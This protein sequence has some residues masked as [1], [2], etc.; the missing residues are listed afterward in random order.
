MIGGFLGCHLQINNCFGYWV[1]GNHGNQNGKSGGKRGHVNWVSIAQH[2]DGRNA[3][4]VSKQSSS[5]EVLMV[6]F[7][8]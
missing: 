1:Q 2:F 4:D 6:N 8:R 7:G 3:K 5:T